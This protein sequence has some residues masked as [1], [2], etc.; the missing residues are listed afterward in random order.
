MNR[1]L[2]TGLSVLAFYLVL[3]RMHE[4]LFSHPAPFAADAFQN[5]RVIW[6][7]FGMLRLVHF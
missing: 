1:F 5:T 6:A 7:I 3:T 4:S 2:G